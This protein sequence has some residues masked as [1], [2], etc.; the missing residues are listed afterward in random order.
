MAS[1]PRSNHCSSVWGLSEKSS[2]LRT[3]APRAVAGATS[4]VESD[5]SEAQLQAFLRPLGQVR[6]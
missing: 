1:V 5:L 2:D 3:R 4:E 6:F